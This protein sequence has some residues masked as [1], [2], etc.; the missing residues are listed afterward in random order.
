MIFGSAS[1]SRSLALPHSAERCMKI[2]WALAHTWR[3]CMEYDFVWHLAASHSEQ[4]LVCLLFLFV[5]TKLPVYQRTALSCLFCRSS[6]LCEVETQSHRCCVP[7]YSDTLN[8]CS[9][10]IHSVFSHSTVTLSSLAVYRTRKTPNTTF[11]SRNICAGNINKL[12]ANRIFCR[13]SRFRQ[14][15][16]LLRWEFFIRWKWRVDERSLS[17]VKVLRES[18]TQQALRE[19]RNKDKK[20]MQ[21]SEGRWLRK[22]VAIDKSI[23]ALE[24][25]VSKIKLAIYTLKIG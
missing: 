5:W 20:E 22:Y 7:T 2:Q 12:H 19:E 3:V 15:W 10:G 6:V 25:H 11:I 9:L 1:L 8:V 16:L 14:I 4:I 21:P 24:W 18:R 23:T 17:N 13:L